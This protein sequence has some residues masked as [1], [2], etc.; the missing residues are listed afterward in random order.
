[1]TNTVDEYL[2]AQGIEVG[3]ELKHFGVK[4]MKWG[5]RR[6]PD[7]L[8][9]RDAK[10]GEIDEARSRVNSRKS[11]IAGAKADLKTAKKEANANAASA[12][13]IKDGREF[14]A[15][16]FGGQYGLA[17]AQAS[18]VAGS[19]DSDRARSIDA[20]RAN[21][22]GLNAS[23]V[24]AKTTLKDLKSL[25]RSDIATGNRIRDGKELAQQL[26]LGSTAR[27]SLAYKDA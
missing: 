17:K 12:G 11:E 1:M 6:S 4:G 18:S 23:R 9:K 26:L 10:R 8:A 24:T 20:A 5:V 27:L 15:W 3:D 7:Q 25:Q 2:A 22:A 21:Q 19:K 16:F 13:R 14:A